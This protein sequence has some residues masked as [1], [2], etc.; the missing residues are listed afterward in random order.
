MK[1]L[2]KTGMFCFAYFLACC[3]LSKAQDA[4]L[5]SINFNDMSEFQEQAGNWTTV[6][7]VWMDPNVDVAHK[8]EKA[9]TGKKRKKTPAVAVPQAVHFQPGSGILLNIN[10]DSKKSNLVT[11]WEHGDIY[12]EM[13]IMVPK[14]SNSGLYLQGR[15]ELQLEDSWGVVAPKFS[16]MGGIFRNWEE[17]PEKSY[18]GKAP[19][20]NAAKAPGLWQTLKVSFQAPKF[21]A[22]GVKISNAKILSAEL[23]G[24]KIHDNVEIPKYTG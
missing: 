4:T 7:E 23:N 18:M 15:Y 11:N 10:D 3:S 17:A 9:N 14:G 20:I 2:M 5:T 6:G 12:I 24:V 16:N 19:L 13:E 8:A 22:S 21:N 1:N